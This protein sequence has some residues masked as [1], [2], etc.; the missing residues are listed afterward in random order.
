[1]VVAH[2]QRELSCTVV[3]HAVPVACGTCCSMDGVD[4]VGQRI[5]R[6]GSN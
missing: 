3:R 6:R 2:E 5:W 1:M 4:V